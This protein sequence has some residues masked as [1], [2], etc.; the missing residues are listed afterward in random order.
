MNKMSVRYLRRWWSR[1]LRRRTLFTALDREERSYI[2][3]TMRV[4]EK[5]RSPTLI[6][7]I[8]KIILKLKDALKSP[9]ATRMENYGAERARTL[10][11][12]A[13]E[14]GH[15]TAE[16]WARERSFARYLTVLDINSKS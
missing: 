5:M 3:L 14:W 15:D 7:E 1:S 10:S 16:G 8:K 4:V 13:T 9:F 2:W 12:L 6:K 11:T